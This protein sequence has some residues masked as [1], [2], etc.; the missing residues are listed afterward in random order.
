MLAYN[1]FDREEEGIYLAAT[2][3]YSGPQSIVYMRNYPMNSLDN[4]HYYE[5]D[6]GQIRT[7]YLDV[8]DAVCKSTR[9]DLVAHTKAYGCAET[10]MQLAPVYIADSF[11]KT[12]VSALADKEIYTIYSE[13]YVIYYNDESIRLE[14]LYV[15]E[16]IAYT[17]CY[18][19][20]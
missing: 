2:M 14:D 5:L 7:S 12:A 17:A 19:V 20:E 9:N 11:D 13:D 10:L 15:K 3:N 18:A 8:S 1:I 6:N 4:R 16:D